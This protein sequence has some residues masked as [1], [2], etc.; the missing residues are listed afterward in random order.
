MKEIID[1]K[2]KLCL[3]HWKQPSAII[4]CKP[5]WTLWITK[6]LRRGNG[7]R[8]KRKAKVEAK[9]EVESS[10]SGSSSAREQ[11]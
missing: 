10:D 8:I 5:G 2:V 11:E 4:K 1:G 7:P 6:G 3:E 9:E